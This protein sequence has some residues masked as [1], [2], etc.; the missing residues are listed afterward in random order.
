MTAIIAVVLFFISW[1]IVVVVGNVQLEI[2]GVFSVTL[3]QTILEHAFTVL[4]VVTSAKLKWFRQSVR[5]NIGGIVI[6]N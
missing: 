1:E 3:L 5:K 2:V 6:I 4:A